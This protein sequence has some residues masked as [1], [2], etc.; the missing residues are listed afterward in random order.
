MGGE[1][2]KKE[3]FVETNR[4]VPSTGVGNR[5]QLSKSNQVELSANTRMGTPPHDPSD[6]I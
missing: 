1:V 3:I 2:D 6:S 5:V 4:K